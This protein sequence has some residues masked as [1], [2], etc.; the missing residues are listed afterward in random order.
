MITTLY[1]VFAGAIGIQ[2]VFLISL[3]Y[4]M[5]RGDHVWYE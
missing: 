5:V 1:L 3:C 4:Y 2:L